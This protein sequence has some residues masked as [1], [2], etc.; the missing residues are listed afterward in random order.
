MWEK[1]IYARQSQPAISN[2]VSVLDVKGAPALTVTGLFVAIVSNFGNDQTNDLFFISILEGIKE[3]AVLDVTQTYMS[4]QLAQLLADLL[5]LLMTDFA[6]GY[7]LLLVQ[8]GQ[9]M[10][11]SSETLSQLE[12]NLATVVPSGL[13]GLSALES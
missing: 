12:N 4:T 6:N 1:A 11:N 7:F 13:G 8:H 9:L 3:P 5:S 2:L 10:R